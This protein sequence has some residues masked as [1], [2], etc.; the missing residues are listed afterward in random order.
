MGRFWEQPFCFFSVCMHHRL[1][2]D[3]RFFD[4]QAAEW[5]SKMFQLIVLFGI[6]WLVHTGYIRM[7]P[8][9]CPVNLLCQ[10][11][12]CS[13]YS[14]DHFSIFL[15]QPP[16][17]YSCMSTHYHL[18]HEIWLTHSPTT[19]PDLQH[20]ESVGVRHESFML[21]LAQTSVLSCCLADTSCCWTHQQYM[22][23]LRAC[24]Q[25]FFGSLQTM[26]TL[27]PLNGDFTD[28]AILSL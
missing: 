28:F 2:V 16:W 6:Q 24:M 5:C 15:R 21:Q 1:I 14:N 13:L 7:M 19:A 22:S 9:W 8:D 26:S 27:K 3:H 17:E 23:M 11:C 12:S 4:Q 10:T 25:Q 18:V 20:R